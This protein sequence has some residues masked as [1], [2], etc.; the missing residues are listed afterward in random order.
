MARRKHHEEELPFVALMDTMT[1]VVGV[2]IIVLVMIGIGLARSVNKVLSELPPVT[3]EQHASLK[4]I[5]ENS[6]PKHDPKTVLEEIAKLQQDAK[7]ADEQLKTMDVTKDAQK[8]KIVDLDDLKKQIAERQ[9]QRDARKADLDKLLAEVDRLKAL[10]DKTPVFAPKPAGPATVVKMPNPRPMPANAD[11]QHFL[12]AGGRITFINGDEIEKLVEQEI[13]NNET[14]LV[15]SRETV[16][17]ADGKPLTVKDK[18]GRVSQQRKVIYDAKKLAEHF[19]KPRLNV[20]GYR[21]EV[22]P[23]PTSPRIPIRITPASDGGETIEQAKM[24]TSNFQR[25]LRQFKAN[26][27]TVVW[28]HVFKDSLP[29]YLEARE[30]V[31]QAGLAAGWEIYAN[32]YYVQYLP[33]QYLVNY[34][35]AP[36]APVGAIPAVTIAPPKATL[37]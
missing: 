19:S 18:L 25:L 10:L 9:K 3:A 5:V 37:D 22:V 20:R 27:R 23:A 13:R 7:K 33:P 14:A 34:T 12:I 31:D 36:P 26:P 16:K 4:K 2:L 21:V 32:P 29:T 17:G 11:I 24:L 28:F 8:V 15:L 6:T 35:P 30:L 1:N